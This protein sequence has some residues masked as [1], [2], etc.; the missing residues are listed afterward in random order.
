MRW[1]FLGVLALAGCS[2]YEP[3]P[4]DPRKMLDE[5]R[6]LRIE[7]PADGLLPDEAVAIALLHNP[8]LRLWRREHEIA[9]QLVLSEGAWANPEFRPTLEDLFSSGGNPASLALGLR[10]FPAPPGENAAKIARAEAR[11]R[12][13]LALVLS[14]E[15]K[16][17]AEVRVVHARAAMLDEK[18]RLVEASLRLH[19]QVSR[20]IDQRLIGFAATRLD[21]ALTTIKGEEL[22]N[23]R[24]SLES[25]RLEALE[26]LSSLL[27]AGPGSV[28]R[29]RKPLQEQDPPVE[30]PQKELEE[31]AL[32]QRP[33]LHALL[34]EYQEREQGLRLAHLAHVFW[35][36]FLEPG[37][38]DLGR[39]PSGE[40]GAA[41][42]IPIFNS[43]SADIA[44]AEAER[45]KAKDAFGAKLE[46]VR[47]EIRQATLQVRESERRKVFHRDRLE[48]VIRQAE[49]LVRASIEAGEADA[50]RLLALE[51][52]VLDSRRDAAQAAFDAERARIE[53]ARATGAVLGVPRK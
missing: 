7:M 42:E 10:I 2:T 46:S 9:E 40:L 18:L 13:T 12:K 20:T 48:P 50:L 16:V 6:A 47:A 45:R 24:F 4:I 31:D 11:E 28:V 22:R 3:D 21:E 37:V 34:E 51:T 29:V 33:D 41:F 49:D 30:R 53:L 25:Q 35:P 27:G 32:K 38:K 52:R 17:A 15:A 1:P 23:D 26:D 39:S 8:E 19:E 14:R 44:V 36:R 43:G 5:I